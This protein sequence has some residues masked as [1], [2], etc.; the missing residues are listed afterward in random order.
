M[1]QIIDSEADNIR[2]L[3]YV[4][5][6]GHKLVSFQQMVSFLFRKPQR[7]LEHTNIILEGVSLAGA[8]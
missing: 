5:K 7:K 2:L 4:F 8:A 3:V 1:E 6:A